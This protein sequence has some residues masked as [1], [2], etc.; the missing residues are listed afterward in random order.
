MTKVCKI[1]LIYA[2]KLKSN[3]KGKRIKKKTCNIAQNHA[4]NDPIYCRIKAFHSTF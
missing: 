4:Q 1:K 3:V 2:S